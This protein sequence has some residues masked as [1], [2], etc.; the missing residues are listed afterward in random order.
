MNRMMIDFETLDVAEMPVIL[1]LA[2]VVF[3]ENKIIDCISEK[4]DQDSC[5]K[6]GC[7]VSVDTLMWW[8]N[9][10]ETAKKAAFGGTTNIGYAM[11][12]LVQFYKDHACAEIW[13]KG[14]IA[15]IRWTNNVLDKLDIKKPWEFWQEM[16]FRT[17]LKCMPILEFK[18]VGEAHNALD[19]AMY[20]AKMWIA[21]NKQNDA[22][23]EIYLQNIT[24]PETS[25]EANENI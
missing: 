5:L 19:D 7:T 3:N 24:Y 4:I 25:G 12:M 6:L 15:D 2:A 10:T 18:R 14:S 8:E 1:S 17:Y 21:A 13:S 11:G 23:N 9:Q 22:R 16:C 20:Q